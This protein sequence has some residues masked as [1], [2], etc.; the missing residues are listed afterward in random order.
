MNPLAHIAQAQV[1]RA[2]EVR[3]RTTTELQLLLY[4][5]MNPRDVHNALLKERPVLEALGR[6]ELRGLDPH[7]L[8]EEARAVG[9][10]D[11]T[12]DDLAYRRL[13]PSLDLGVYCAN[14]GVGK[15]SAPAQA[16]LDQFVAQWAVF[17]IDGFMEAGWLDLVEDGRFLIGELCGDPALIHG[18]VAWF[19]NLSDG[20]S[21]CLNSLRGRLV[22]TA[23]HFTTGHY[24]HENWA[25]RTESEVVVVPE[26][27]Q[28]CVPT[29]AVIDALTP[30]TTVV[31]LSQVHWRSGY[32]HDLPAIAAA[33]KAVCPSATL[34]LDVYQG[35]GTV[36]VDRAGLPSRTAMLGGGLKQLHAGTG[37]GYGWF[38]NS[39]LERISPDRIGWWAHAEPIAF[40]PAPLRMGPGAAP[41]RT[42]T[43]A[44]L[45]LVLLVTELKVLAASGGGGSLTSGVARAR[46]RTSQIVAAA[47][48]QAQARGLSVRGPT[49][50]A[51]RG[52]FFAIE[53][54]D[55]AFALDGLAAAGV[56]ADFRADVPGGSA[57]LVRISASAAHFAYELDYAVD[58][59]AR[60]HAL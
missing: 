20:L 21:A 35:H 59:L 39:L 15:P 8:R 9:M 12:A 58:A 13:F 19:P 24:I 3:G 29:Q 23:A 14:H 44:L 41:L 50:P 2:R 1:E 49:D 28:E 27:D 32:V 53:V 46:A 40:E 54:P 51:R 11:G 48:A 56:T 7:E 34:L 55:G 43:P 22:T 52:A 16:A 47:V 57:G 31:S 38:S 18:D 37:A 60:L 25:R 26:D 42:G 45:P 17:G 6:M 4:R 33:M 36:P 5:A 30:D 10:L